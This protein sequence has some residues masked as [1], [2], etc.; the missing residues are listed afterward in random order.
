MR[1][2]LFQLRLE[3]LVFLIGN[4]L[5]VEDQYAGDVVVVGLLTTG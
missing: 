2:E 3:Q 4:G 1:S 5:L